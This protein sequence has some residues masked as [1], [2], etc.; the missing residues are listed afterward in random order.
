M[1]SETIESKMA[2]LADE[3]ECCSWRTTEKLISPTFNRSRSEEFSKYDQNDRVERLDYPQTLILGKLLS[4]KAFGKGSGSRY[5]LP[6]TQYLN[7]NLRYIAP[8]IDGYGGKYVHCSELFHKSGLLLSN[9]DVLEQ[10]DGT[11]KYVGKSIQIETDT[12]RKVSEVLIQAGVLHEDPQRKVLGFD[13]RSN[14]IF[15]DY[16]FA[17]VRAAYGV[18][19]SSLFAWARPPQDTHCSILAFVEIYEGPVKVRKT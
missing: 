19:D 14:I 15:N 3:L 6:S 7:K 1:A 13:D 8:E 4:E 12:K 2:R 18:P 16:G 5:V 9:P 11:W 17:S 10:K